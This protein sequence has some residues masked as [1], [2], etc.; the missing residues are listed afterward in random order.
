[1]CSLYWRQCFSHCSKWKHCPEKKTA[2][3]RMWDAL[4]GVRK[5]I[6]LCRSPEV[7]WGKQQGEEKQQKPGAQDSGSQPQPRHSANLQRRGPSC[8]SNQ[9]FGIK[10]I[11]WRTTDVSW[12]PWN[13]KKGRMNNEIAS[14][15]KHYQKQ[16]KTF[17]KTNLI[18]DKWHHFSCV[19]V[20]VCV[21]VYFWGPCLKA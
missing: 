21:C 11:R 14:I 5:S 10:E 12:L 8:A 19:C 2:R 7:M 18:S 17:R 20:C 3:I 6:C 4:R 15:Q 16:K 13:M 9:T 1:M